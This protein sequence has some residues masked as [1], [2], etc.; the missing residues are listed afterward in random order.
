MRQG[1]NR[2]KVYI[3]KRELKKIKNFSS[4]WVPEIESLYLSGFCGFETSLAEIFFDSFFKEVLDP[5]NIFFT[6]K[7]S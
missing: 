5:N 7:R 1:L 3:S 2:V 6:V 4:E